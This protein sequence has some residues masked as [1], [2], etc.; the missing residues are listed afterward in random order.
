MVEVLV[1]GRSA[2]RRH[3]KVCKERTR[4]NQLVESMNTG[5]SPDSLALKNWKFNQEVSRKAMVNFIVL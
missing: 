3:L 2:C 4:K 5:L 1:N